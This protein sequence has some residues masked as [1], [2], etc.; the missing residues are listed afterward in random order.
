MHHFK[1]K[2]KGAIALTSMVVLG[3]LVVMITFSMLVLGISGRNVVIALNQSGRLFVESDGCLE[4]AL[5]QLSR[6]HNYPGSSYVVGDTDCVVTVSGSAELR[7]I[8]VDASDN[9]FYQHLTAE[10]QLA[11]VFGLSGFHY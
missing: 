7:T 2:N 9:D 4:E 10:I 6:D 11:P 8:V 1:S 5:L 3:S